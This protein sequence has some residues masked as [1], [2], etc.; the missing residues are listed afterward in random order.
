MLYKDVK[1]APS[2]GA[3][4]TAYVYFWYPV[5]DTIRHHQR[6]TRCSQIH[7][8]ILRTFKAQDDQKI[9]FFDLSS[10][11]PELYSCSLSDYT[12]HKREHTNSN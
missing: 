5:L 9:L 8:S 1:T 2:V 10:I 3:K 12:H 7:I 4:C 6:D 11:S